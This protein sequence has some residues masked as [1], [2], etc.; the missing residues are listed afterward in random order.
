MPQTA[1][2]RAGLHSILGPVATQGSLESVLLEE[3]A[4]DGYV[5]RLVSYNVPAG[6]ASAFVCI[7]NKLTAP[8]PVVY[9]HHQHH[10]QFDLGKSEVCG[11][12]GDPDQAY[13]AELA[14]RG[15]ITISPDAIGFED[16]NWAEAKNL[17]WFELSSRLV[18]GRTLL[19]DCLQEV[20]IALDYAT[21]LPEADPSRIGFIGHS[22]GGR[23]AIWAP[24]WDERIIASVSNCGCIPY[25][26]SF[27]HDAG[28]QAELVV[29]DFAS[30]YDLEDVLA[31][32]GQCKTLLIA[33]EDDVWSRGA[34]DIESR[35]RQQGVTHVRVDVVPG[36]HAFPIQQ[37]E[38]AYEFLE[39]NL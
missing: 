2:T 38:M 27:S 18:L 10:G 21:S 1:L 36:R 6:R 8:A 19:A 24:A 39:L 14:Q 17:G 22:Y 4:C 25:R 34:H 12:R 37:R 16:R 13:A 28:F 5:R 23:I 15:F 30:N 31:I 11:L 35:L 29:P 9:C 20:S 3:V 26:D 32:S 33:A 7:P